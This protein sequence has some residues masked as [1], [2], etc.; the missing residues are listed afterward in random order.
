LSRH[1][2][3][4]API[5]LIG[6]ARSGTKLLRDCLA[7]DP[8]VAR[9]PHDINY[10]WRLGNEGSPHD[11]L[12]PSAMTP[13]IRARIRSELADYARGSPVLIEKTVGNALRVP[14]VAS[15][16]PEARFVHLI[17]DG[18]DVIESVER[19]WQAKPDWSSLVRKA[20]SFPILEAPG[21]AVRYA[22][23]TLRRTAGR[24]PKGAVWGPRYDGITED[25]NRYDLLTVCAKQWVRCVES[26]LAG[27]ATL[28][29][30]R[31]HTV[32]YEEFVIDPRA[33]LTGVGSFL[34]L[35]F[36]ETN[37]ATIEQ[38]VSPEHIGKGRTYLNGERNEGALAVLSPGLRA[39]G[40]HEV[41]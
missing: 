17:R 13:E 34:G 21:Y 35:A 39:L 5:V 26:A 25:L 33:T 20:R 18:R 12:D 23:D 27:L 36:E 41:A 19:Q 3:S 22:R 29:S 32:R 40:Y 31:V 2:L 10:V 28:P 1:K 11:E 14:F 16:L 8:R 37:V 15:V 38:L 30:E 9:V 24:S 7:L 6:A 4:A